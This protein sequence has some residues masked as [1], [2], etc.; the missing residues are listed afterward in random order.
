MLPWLAVVPPTWAQ[1]LL[2][3]ACSVMECLGNLKL[4]YVSFSKTIMLLWHALELDAL[5]LAAATHYQ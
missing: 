3:K 4:M 5:W 2:Q 1:G